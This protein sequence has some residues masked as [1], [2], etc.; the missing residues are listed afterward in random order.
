MGTTND[1]PWVRHGIDSEGSDWR[2]HVAP[3]GRA[4]DRA[5]YLFPTL[6]GIEAL[7]EFAGDEYEA[8]QPGVVGA[9]GRGKRVPWRSIAGIV[10]CHLPG[11]YWDEHPAWSKDMTPGE[12]GSRAHATVVCAIRDRMLDLAVPFHEWERFTDVSRRVFG[13]DVELYAASRLWKLE[14]KCDIPAASTG[15]LFLQTSERNPLCRY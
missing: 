15:G 3:I 6:A 11:W 5:I 9:T 8:G 10:Q 14:I 12:K 4:W 7:H 13:W 1:S 2:A